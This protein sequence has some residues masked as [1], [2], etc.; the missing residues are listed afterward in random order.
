M[1]IVNA[2]VI[3]V[4]PEKTKKPQPGI[5]VDYN[6]AWWITAN[7]K[8]FASTLFSR[9]VLKDI[10]VTLKIRDLDM[11]YLRFIYIDQCSTGDFAISRGFYFLETSHPRKFA[12]MKP[13]RKFPNLQ[14]NFFQSQKS[15]NSAFYCMYMYFLACGNFCGLLIIFANSLDKTFVL[16]WILTLW[17]FDSVPMKEYSEKVNFEKKIR[18]RQQKH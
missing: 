16:I 14:W 12:K 7:S 13:L 15:L 4:Y 17:H 10:F 8:F 11:I 5:H 3:N 6:K 9:I 1:K 18:R 2:H